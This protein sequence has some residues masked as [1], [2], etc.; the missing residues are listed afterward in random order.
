MRF[1][2]P[3]PKHKKPVINAD[4]SLPLSNNP[5]VTKY[6]DKYR[7]SE[8]QAAKEMAEKITAEKNT[9]KSEFLLDLIK[10]LIIAIA[11]LAIEHFMD[12][13]RFVEHLFVQ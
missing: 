12:I 13:V 1:I 2:P 4:L 11:T 9:K 6:T 7:R 5:K 10:A 8:E 3:L